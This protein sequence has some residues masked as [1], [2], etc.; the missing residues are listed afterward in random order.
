MS[1]IKTNRSNY[2]MTIIDFITETYCLI[3]DEVKILTKNKNLRHRGFSP[4]LS[5]SEVITMEVVG[6][7]LGH[8]KDTH[9]WK[10]FKNNMK[11]MFPKIGSRC[12]FIKQSANLWHIKQLIQQELIMKYLQYEKTYIVDGFPVPVCHYARASRCKSFNEEAGYGYCAAKDE[13]YYGFKGHLIVDEDGIIHSFTLTEPTVDERVALK[14]ICGNIKGLLLGDKGYISRE[15]SEELT[16][17]GT[18]L[19]TPVRSNMDESRPKWFLKYLQAKR[20]IVETV[21]S[22]LSRTFNIQSIRV[23]DMWHLTN[24]F[25]RKILAHNICTIINLKNGFNILAIEPLVN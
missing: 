13:K 16:E 20:K 6:E 3:D 24:R 12:N 18:N 22:Q 15:L 1:P 4:E 11:H 25:T 10:C 7:Y 21:I 2:T 9:I 8:S 5:D 19:Q 23:R 17:Y 14:D